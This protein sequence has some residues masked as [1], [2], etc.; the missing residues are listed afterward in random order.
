MSADLTLWQPPDKELVSKTDAYKQ[1]LEKSNDL[2]VTEL[3]AEQRDTAMRRQIEVSKKFIDKIEGHLD[4]ISDLSKKEQRQ[5]LRSLAETMSVVS[6]VQSKAAQFDHIAKPK[7]QEEANGRINLF[8]S[9]QPLKVSDRPLQDV[10][11]T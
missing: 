6:N 1:H 7:P 4:D 3:I 11:G 9:C 8:V 2:A 5:V 10:T